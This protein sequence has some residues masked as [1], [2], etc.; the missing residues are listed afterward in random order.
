MKT[1]IAILLAYA[2]IAVVALPTPDIDWSVYV[3]EN[4]REGKS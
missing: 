2:G 4:K 3:K 1:A